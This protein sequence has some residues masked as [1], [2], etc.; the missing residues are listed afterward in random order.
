MFRYPRPNIYPQV[1][2]PDDKVFIGHP[3]KDH[4]LS[5][6]AGEAGAARA[7]KCADPEKP[8]IRFDYD[9]K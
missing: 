3:L 1:I 2:H 6:N 9:Y 7:I 8:V 4:Q 5:A